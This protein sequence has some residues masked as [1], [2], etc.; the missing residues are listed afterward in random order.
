M[1]E[2]DQRAKQV[3]VVGA[4]A[5]LTLTALKFVFGI[6]TSSAALLADAIHSLSD[7]ISDFVVYVAILLAQE[8][9][10]RTI[11]MAIADLKQLVQSLLDSL[12]LQLG[13]G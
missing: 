11:N 10:M 13:L 5:N 8:K 7:L 12:S 4:L 9:R 6:V 2:R 3:T 1:T